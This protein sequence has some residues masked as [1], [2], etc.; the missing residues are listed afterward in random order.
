MDKNMG[1]GKNSIEALT[2]NVIRSALVN[3]SETCLENE[4]FA[5]ALFCVSDL[6]E[7]KKLASA[8]VGALSIENCESLLKLIGGADNPGA[9][10]RAIRGN[11]C[12]EK[13]ACGVINSVCGELVSNIAAGGHFFASGGHCDEIEKISE[14]FGLEEV[15][16]RLMAFL[17]VWD[18]VAEFKALCGDACREAAPI[19][20]FSFLAG[21]LNIKLCEVSDSIK[22]MCDKCI[23]EGAARSRFPG[24]SYKISEYISEFDGSGVAEKFSRVWDYGKAFKLSTFPVAAGEVDIILKLLRSKRP[25]H[26]LLYG[27]AGSGKSEFAKALAKKLRKRVCVPNRENSSANPSRTSVKAAIFAAA[28]SRALA[29]I[30][31][32]GD[33]LETSPAGYHPGAV[34]REISERTE[35]VNK[36]L[37]EAKGAVIWIAESIDGIDKS[38]RGRFTYS[39]HI[40]GISDAQKEIAIKN[41]LAK[42]RLGAHLAGLMKDVSKRYGLT[43]AGIGLVLEKA[44]G[45][46]R[47]E[48]ELAANIEKIAKAR[49]ELM[50]AKKSDGGEFK[51]DW[52]FDASI[53][54]IDFPVESILR[55]LE[56]YKAAVASGEKIPMSFLFSGAAG[57]GKTQL[58]R[59][60]ARELGR[61]LVIKRMSEILSPYIGETEKNIRKMFAEA[62]RDGAALMID[63]ADSLFYDRQNARRSWEVSH[64]NE[65]LAQME[66]FRGVFIC[67]TNLADNMDAAA[68][69]RFNWKVKFLPPTHEGRVKLY[70]RYFLDGEAPCKKIEDELCAMDG[71]CPGDFYAVWQKTRFVPEK[72][73]SL[74]IGALKS[75]LGYKKD[76]PFSVG[77]IG[78]C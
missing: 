74:I 25:Q 40:E 39:L 29:L 20:I 5:P 19:K 77:R 15:D 63:E 70:S 11:I 49:Y 71:L 61:E 12:D 18:A 51:V 16:K 31:D 34:A 50:S 48:A 2:K 56:N 28:K 75:E 7:I 67:T 62:A 44:A 53:L 27:A 3:L 59:F 64:V 41:S 6:S 23:L 17:W 46:S 72:S 4:K 60:I 78:F 65:I 69:R 57:T 76:V 1:T 68:M 37:D 21:A 10:I 36:V 9:I 14:F 66:T 24:I 33:F 43:A 13:E 32:A 30:D 54:N 73:E 35:A 42:N 8:R 45:I 47:A 52:R 38:T 55:T 26:I 58:G 22:R